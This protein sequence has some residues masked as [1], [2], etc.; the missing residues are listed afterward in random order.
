MSRKLI[1]L[2]VFIVFGLAKLP[3][4][5]RVLGSLRE[6][7]LVEAPLNLELRENIGQMGFAASLGGLRSLVASITYL[8]AYVAF[9]DVDW[10]RVDSLM[11]L[12]TRLQPHEPEYWGDASWH[13][14][15][16]AAS[17]YM[18]NQDLRFA[19][20]NKLFRDYVQ[21]GI[22]ILDEGLRYLPNNPQLLT[23][24][25]DIYRDRQVDHR[26]AAYCYLTAAAHGAKDYYKRMGAYQLVLLDDRDSW[27][28]AYAILKKDYD[29]HKS[30]YERKD[31]A[32]S[33]VMRDLPILEQRLNIP[34]D[35]RIKP[36]VPLHLIK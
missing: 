15:Y 12:T 29:D 16:N 6:Q 25:G 33:S 21:R 32:R 18:N 35:K 11:T 36:V 34:V 13:M 31:M 27:E 24:L 28:K 22:D 26:K 1:G 30:V 3:V 4:E 19:I 2:F 7:N 10:G 8:Q 17:N 20:R 9:E 5:D 14:A 23:R